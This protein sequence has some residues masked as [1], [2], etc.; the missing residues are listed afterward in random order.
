MINDYRPTLLIKKEKIPNQYLSTLWG[1]YV[2]IITDDQEIAKML[3]LS[4]KHRL[5]QSGLTLGNKFRW[6]R[7]L[8]IYSKSWDQSEHRGKPLLKLSKKDVQRGYDILRAFG[9]TSQDWFVVFILL[10]IK[11]NTP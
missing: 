6:I 7:L 11:M 2:D 10:K 4:Y 5:F 3:P 9:I 1:K 8:L